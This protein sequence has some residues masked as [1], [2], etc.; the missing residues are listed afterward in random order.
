LAAIYKP[1]ML[2]GM[3][4]RGKIFTAVILLIIIGLGAAGWL[5]WSNRDKATTVYRSHGV[6]FNYGKTWRLQNLTDQDKKDNFIFWANQPVDQPIFQ[7]TVRYE[8]GIAK[9]ASVA[10]KEPM[11][12]LV[13]NLRRTYPTRFPSF[14]EVSSRRYN[15]DGHQA[16][17]LIFTYKK[18]SMAIKQRFG[19]YLKDSNTAVYIAS[20]SKTG[21]YEK[22]NKRFFDPLYSSVSFY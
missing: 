14:T 22:I 12:M 18:G 4:R 15:Q 7:T 16:A 17:E 1:G 8:D 3:S 20:Q 11:D 9:A 5:W 21:D 19:L 6:S 13:E 2:L 10:K